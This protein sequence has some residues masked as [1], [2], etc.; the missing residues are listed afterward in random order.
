MIK[1][2]SQDRDKGGDQ[3]GPSLEPKPTEHRSPTP[4]PED[5]SE[6]DAAR[7]K[8]GA[9]IDEKKK[10]ETEAEK[11]VEK[12]GEKDS[13]VI[14]K[15]KDS[16]DN[17]KETDNETKGEKPPSPKKPPPPANQAP[18]TGPVATT[19]LRGK[20]KATGQMMGGWL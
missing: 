6:E 18:E 12:G 2:I 19:K 17:K 1:S 9:S 5:P 11:D 3:A 14:G 13:A 10:T 20:S 7:I 15:E 8:S 16:V 4:I